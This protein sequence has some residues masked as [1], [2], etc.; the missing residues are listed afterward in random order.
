MSSKFLL[1]E[2]DKEKEFNQVAQ[3]R[4]NGQTDKTIATKIKYIIKSDENRVKIL[5]SN[6]LLDFILSPIL[7]KSIGSTI[8]PF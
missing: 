4:I 5:N 2:K 6:N 7:L 3:E 1:P 8:F